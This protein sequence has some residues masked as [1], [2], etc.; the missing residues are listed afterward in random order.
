M[1]PRPRRGA[2]AIDP[3]FDHR[4]MAAALRLGRRNLGHTGTNPAVGC[5]IVR[6]ERQ[7]RI[8]VGRGWTAVGGRPHAEKEALAEAGAAAQ[9]AT[10]YVTLE[11]CAH[12]GAVPPCAEA[13]IAA[14]VARVVSA[15]EDPDPRTVGRGHAR[16]AAAGIAV[17]TGILVARAAEAH[18][19]HI[20]R[21]KKA[22]PHVTLKLAVSADGMIGK[23]V[24]ERMLI[25]GLPAFEAVQA[26]RTTFDVVMIG[27]GTV[28]TDDPNLTVR[29][30]GLSARSPARVILDANAR[31]P[32]GSRLVQSAKETPLIA[33]IGAAAPAENKAALAEAGVTLIEA[34]GSGDKLDLGAALAA[35]SEH[36][37]TRVFAEG[38]AQVAASL[39]AGDLVDEVVLFRAD[40]VVG[41]DGV[42]AL[43][44]TALSAIERSPRYALAETATFGE[45]TM[46][47]Y[48]RAG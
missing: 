2:P 43:A 31:L 26:M 40:V 39:I 15:M 48:L 18:S 21:M 10:A 14:G 45:D 19:G 37:F 41:P 20:A 34:P 12:E 29:L 17:T 5:I 6:Q 30:P 16:L 33:I 4:M 3:E 8:V 13:L 27:I 25:S 32:V 35:L 24:G 42:R 7:A 1:A 22:R 38:G 11:P 47:R 46:R 44:G 9:G 28:M 36:G 23:R